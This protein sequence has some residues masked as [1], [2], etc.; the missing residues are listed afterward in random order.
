MRAKTSSQQMFIFLSC[1]MMVTEIQAHCGRPVVGPNKILTEETEKESFPSGDTLVFQCAP[2]YEQPTSSK[3][4]CD[5]RQWSHL[6]LQ[7]QRKSCG[8][9]VEISNG[10]YSYKNGTLFGAKVTAE[11][12]FG[13]KL[14]GENTRTCQEDGWDGKDPVC[15][16]VKCPEPNKGLLDEPHQEETLYEKVTNTDDTKVQ[17]RTCVHV[18]FL[19]I[20]KSVTLK[21]RVKG[22]VESIMWKFQNTKVVEHANSVTDWHRFKHQGHLNIITGDLTLENL[23]RNNCGTYECEILVNGELMRSKYVI[24]VR[25]STVDEKTAEESLPVTGGNPDAP[26]DPATGASEKQTD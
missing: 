1:L 11:C 19:E 10:K 22:E 8:R 21:P 15:E 3:I 6:Q 23:K 14:V 17:Y 5:G 26:H 16:V 20:G 2:G 4:I 24:T 18:D 9:L 12:D 7:C 25:E 13:Y